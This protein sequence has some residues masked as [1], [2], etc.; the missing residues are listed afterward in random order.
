[1]QI[2]TDMMKKINILNDT[3]ELVCRLN[4]INDNNDDVKHRVYSE[5]IKKLAEYFF[6]I[7]DN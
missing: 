6:T 4:K 3:N 2:C 7:I 1:M 5:F